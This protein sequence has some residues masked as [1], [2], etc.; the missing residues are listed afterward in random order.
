MENSL[1]TFADAIGHIILRD[2]LRTLLPWVTL[3]LVGCGNDPTDVPTLLHLASSNSV[4]KVEECIT[5][6][7]GAQL[8]PGLKRVPVGTYNAGSPQDFL[9]VTKDDQWIVIQIQG[10]GSNVL[11]KGNSTLSPDQIG[12]VT[13][14]VRTTSP[15][16]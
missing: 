8:L 6:P 7:Q 2:V 16:I 9:L 11:V 3:I 4:W 14:C 13:G 12:F 15:S 10:L 5:S 1:S